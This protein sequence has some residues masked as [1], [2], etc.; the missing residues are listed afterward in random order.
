MFKHANMRKVITNMI[1]LAFHMI[2][3]NIGYQQGPKFYIS[4][5]LH[6]FNKLGNLNN[7]NK[8]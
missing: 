2:L 1:R 4:V 6:Y 8:F 5:K 3:H 7:G